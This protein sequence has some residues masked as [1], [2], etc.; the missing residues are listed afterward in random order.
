MLGGRRAGR[1]PP[2]G[3]G[4]GSAAPPDLYSSDFNILITILF[5]ALDFI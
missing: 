4:P 3:P 5:I 2:G 1:A